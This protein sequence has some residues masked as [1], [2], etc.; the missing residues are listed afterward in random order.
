MKQTELFERVIKRA[1]LREG[2][3]IFRTGETVKRGEDSYTA[4]F[5][6]VIENFKKS[7]RDELLFKEYEEMLKYA[8]IPV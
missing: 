8:F 4:F 1:R 3:I 6:S 5:D 2:E 7:L